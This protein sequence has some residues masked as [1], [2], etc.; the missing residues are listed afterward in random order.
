MVSLA[1]L[2]PL[3]FLLVGLL[4]LVLP[5]QSKFAGYIGSLAGLLTVLLS[6]AVWNAH[7]SFT[8]TWF[9]LFGESITWGAFVDPLSLLLSI[10]I[11]GIGTLIFLYSTA[12]FDEG[13][14]LRR[15]FFLLSLFASSML[16]VVLSTNLLQLFFCWEL[17]GVSSFLLIGFWH[18]KASAVRAAKKAFL[19]IILGDVFL[20]LGILSLRLSYGTFDIQTILS[21]LHFDTLTVLGAIGILIGAISKSAQ[22]P[23]HAWLPDAM[24]GPTPVSAFLHS[25]TMVKAGLFLVA[26][27]LPLLILA[28]LG[29]TLV[30]IAIITIFLSALIA[31]VETDVKRVLAYSTMNHLAFILLAL[32]LGAT[33]AGLYHLATH[34]VAKALL[35]LSAGVI[36]HMAGTQDM[37]K[38]NL[39]GG[40][41]L[42]SICSLLGV[43]SLAGIP[44]F[45][46]F[47]SKD[48]IFESVI[49]T[50]NPLLIGAFSVAI[51]LSSLYLFRWY[52]MVFHPKTDLFSSNS[53]AK[54]SIH[55]QMLLPLVILAI[56]VAVL[57]ALGTLISSWL[58]AE[59]GHFGVVAVVSII[60]SLLGF[61]TAYMAFRKNLSFS[62]ISD[63]SFAMACRAKFL[64]DDMTLWVGMIFSR[65]SS[66]V[67]WADDAIVNRGVRGVGTSITGVG[68]SMRKIQTGKSS[69]YLVAFILGA[70]M[71]IILSRWTL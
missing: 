27:M 67:A 51:F 15:F 39:H 17:V 60:L 30:A 56:P 9:S 21:S 10:L 29:N 3:P 71:L 41:G 35:F 44:P 68:S 62:W 43:A 1:L 22:F 31:L 69:T 4:A 23:L 19:T 45:S 33:G 24:E 25:A 54:N 47:F 61:F 5:R 64:L 37:T 63:S 66:G 58:G 13:E 36:I 20:F 6:I 14:D 50:Q 18:K 59:P 7:G 32:G 28:G 34:S 2:I 65:L 52:F 26:R 49:H 57:G 8:V 70:I 46:G 48:A 53:H 55:W 40:W 11:A 42:L 12:Y 16:G 38:M